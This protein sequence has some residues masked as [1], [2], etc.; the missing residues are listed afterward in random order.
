VIDASFRTP[1]MRAA[2]RILARKHGVPFHFVECRAPREVCRARLVKRATE[3]HVSDGRVEIF[4]AFASK[5]VPSREV[6]PDELVL[7]DTTRS[8]IEQLALLR[9]SIDV[10]PLGLVG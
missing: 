5:W 1:A 6:S 4:D 7:L 3:T 10:W 9:A 8:E 2:A